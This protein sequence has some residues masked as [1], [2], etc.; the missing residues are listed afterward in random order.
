MCSMKVSYDALKEKG[1]QV[2]T[3]K[4]FWCPELDSNQHTLAGAAT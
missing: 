3:Y 2:L 4:P 1:L